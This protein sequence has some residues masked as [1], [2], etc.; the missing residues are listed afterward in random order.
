MVVIWDIASGMV[1]RRIPVDGKVA[2]M[3]YEEGRNVLRIGCERPYWRV[4]M[5]VRPV[6]GEVVWRYQ[7][8]KEDPFF[9]E[10]CGTAQR[11]PNGNTLITESNEGRAFEVTREGETVW[12]YFVPHLDK[13]GHRATI[14]RLYRYEKA[15]VEPLL[16]R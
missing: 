4:A 1:V 9:S 10:T 7:G 3:E 15:F 6:S 14:I 11:L 2:W 5:T 16:A 13:K 8:T 12:E